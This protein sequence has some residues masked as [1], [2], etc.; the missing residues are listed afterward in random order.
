MHSRFTV[1]TELGYEVVE[2][3]MET[4]VFEETDSD[5][6]VKPIGTVWCP[7]AS[8]LD[9]GFALQSQTVFLQAAVGFV[10]YGHFNIFA[11]KGRSQ[12]R[13]SE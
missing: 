8:D 5:E 11:M 2:D 3:T 13:L 1:D 9:D 10:W 4:N 6:V 7:G 12:I